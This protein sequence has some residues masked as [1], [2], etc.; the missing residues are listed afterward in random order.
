MGA[1]TAP[2]TGTAPGADGGATGAEGI[3]SKGD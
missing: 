3:G 2:M 1:A